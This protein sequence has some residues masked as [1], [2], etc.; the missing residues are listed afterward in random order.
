M[1]QRIL[2]MESD[3]DECEPSTNCFPLNIIICEI[4]DWFSCIKSN[5][6]RTQRLN[7]L[8][9]TDSRDNIHMYMLY[10]GKDKRYN[11]D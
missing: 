5:N 9:V 2:W 10:K 4:S 3:G 1:N 8:K 7:D 11:N 6:S